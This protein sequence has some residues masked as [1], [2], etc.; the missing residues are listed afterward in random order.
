[1]RVYYVDKGPRLNINARLYY[2]H[3][4]NTNVKVNIYDPVNNYNYVE[5]TKVNV[6]IKN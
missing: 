4:S 5:D 1:M 3:V 6:S 2:L